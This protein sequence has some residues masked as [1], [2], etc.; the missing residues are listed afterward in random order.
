MLPVFS[1]SVETQILFKNPKQSNL[2]LQTSFPASEGWGLCGLQHLRGAWELGVQ[3]Q[4]KV[5]S[6]YNYD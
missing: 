1:Y 6:T 2:V 5:G 4:G 3:E